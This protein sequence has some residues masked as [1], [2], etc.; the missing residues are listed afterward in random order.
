MKRVLKKTIAAALTAAMVLSLA[1]ANGAEAAK[2]PKLSKK[3][4]TLVKG[5]TLKLTVKNGNKKAKVTWKTNKKKI[6]KITKKSSKGNKAYAKV[7][8]LKKGKANITASYKLGKKTTKLV[9]KITVKENG[10]SGQQGQGGTTASTAP[11]TTTTVAPGASTVPGGDT[12]VSAPPTATD[13]SGQQATEEPEKTP[14]PT[15]SPKPPTA[16]PKNSAVEAHRL[17]QDEQVVVNGKVDKLEN[18][19]IE[20]ENTKK[21]EIDLLVNKEVSLRGTSTITAA[22]AFLMWAD[23]TENGENALY[24]I[25]KVTKPGDLGASD[26]VTLFLSEDGTKVEKA[27]AVVGADASDKGAALV[28]KASDEG[29]VDGYIAEL[30]LPLSKKYAVDVDKL[31]IDI[32]ITDGDA[33]INYF[34]TMTEYDLAK[35]ANGNVIVNEDN[36]NIAIPSGPAVSVD[37]DAS[38]MG[39]VALIAS[40]ANPAKAFYTASGSAIREIADYEKN[41]WDWEEVAEPAEGEEPATPEDNGIKSKK[42]SFVP[43]SFWTSVYEENKSRSIFFPNINTT[44]YMMD[45]NITLADPLKDDDGN[46]IKGD[47]GKV[48]GWEASDEKVQSYV[49][50]DEEYVY[51]LFDVNDPDI[52][53]LNDAGDWQSDSVEFFL[54]QD[55]RCE[56]YNETLGEGD[57]VQLRVVAANNQ[58]AASTNNVSNLGAYELV[59]HTVA[60]KKGENGYA[61]AYNAE[62]V[63]GYQVEMIIKLQNDVDHPTPKNGQIMGIDLQI[64]DCYNDVEK[65]DDGN[66]VEGGKTVIARAGTVTAFDTTN[67]CYQDP[68]CFGRV[69]LLGGPQSGG[70]EPT[71]PGDVEATW[72]DAE[73]TIDGQIDKAWDDA[74]FID[75]KNAVYAQG[76]DPANDKTTSAKTKLM[77]DANNLYVLVVVEDADID[78]TGTETYQ[79]DGGEIFLNEDNSK[80]VAYADNTDAFQYRFSGMSLDG[81]PAMTKGIESGSDAAKAAYAGIDSAYAVTKDENGAVTGYVIEHKIPWRKSAKVG[82]Q[83]SFELNVF[84]CSGGKRNRELYLINTEDKE[85][86]KNA[87][88]FGKLDLVKKP[89]EEPLLKRATFWSQF[90]DVKNND[91]GSI[92]L[93]MQEGAQSWQKGEFGFK[94]P[95]GSTEGCTKVIIKYRDADLT[96]ADATTCGY[97]FHFEGDN[98]GYVNGESGAVGNS[99]TFNGSGT[100]VLDAGKS[101]FTTARVFDGKIGGKITIESIT[102]E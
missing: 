26:K 10:A 9:C 8:A 87:A 96:A 64:N 94:F 62:G 59:A 40:M 6:A 46:V 27:E 29:G 53:A 14:T 56:S 13:G 19:A 44:G 20:W 74:D 3:T 49:L 63:T 92:T 70:D 65:D 71:E 97:I 67:N 80:E 38:K 98:P 47:D 99:L 84:D 76:A 88:G 39:E 18:N 55:Y 43:T 30:K 75:V 60:Y 72:T 35:D 58:F 86:Y 28:S 34:D 50:W 77:W 33:T 32:M 73:I 16:L 48:S 52:T 24:A 101:D 41:K 21:K 102:L 93:E 36:R 25:V 12:Q 37:K 2:K 42:M 17:G 22:K 81:S 51:V 23:E 31:K 90:C 91:D 78:T 45:G 7:K 68:S 66:P 79:R 61:N 1:P 11:S 54:D 57:A 100:A 4:A 85:L 5:K 82:Q 95:A 89:K 83:V 69:K 15:K